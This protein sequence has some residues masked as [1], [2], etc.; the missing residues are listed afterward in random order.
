MMRRD[1]HDDLINLLRQEIG[2]EVESV[3]D[4]CADHRAFQGEA[5]QV[6]IEFIRERLNAIF[7]SQE[8][9]DD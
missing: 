3:L 6:T 8:D 5:S 7:V 1:P 4:T 9:D 2:A